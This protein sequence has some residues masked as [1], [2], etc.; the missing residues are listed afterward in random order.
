MRR[1]RRRRTEE[2]E[3]E[4]S[5]SRDDIVACVIFAFL[6]EMRKRRGAR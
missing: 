1:R 5:P 6:K 4:V 3:V 2:E